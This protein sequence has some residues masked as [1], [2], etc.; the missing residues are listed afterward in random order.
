ME[1]PVYFHEVPC[2]TN[3]RDLYFSLLKHV[4]LSH[5]DFMDYFVFRKSEIDGAPGNNYKLCD[6]GYNL[7]N[8][9]FTTIIKCALES[10]KVFI[11]VVRFQFSK[12]KQYLVKLLLNRCRSGILEASCECVAGAGPEGCCNYTAS[13]CYA[14]EHFSKTGILLSVQKH[15]LMFYK[16][17]TSPHGKGSCMQVL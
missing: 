7:F 3:F 8:E 1:L 5:L 9:R 14:F 10:N 4:K 6:A 17:F 12:S 16:L 11:S 2:D 15:Q 13:V